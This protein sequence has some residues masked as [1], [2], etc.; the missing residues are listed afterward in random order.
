ME[1]ASWEVYW[2]QLKLWAHTYTAQATSLHQGS[3]YHK[4]LRV[5]FFHWVPQGGG[6][7]I[8]NQTIFNSETDGDFVCWKTIMLLTEPK[9][10]TT[11]C[12]Y[13]ACLTGITVQ[14]KR[15]MEFF[16]ISYFDGIIMTVAHMSAVCVACA[17]AAFLECVYKTGT[18]QANFLALLDNQLGLNQEGYGPNLCVLT[19]LAVLNSLRA[20]F[21]SLEQS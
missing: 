18:C 6:R 20:I 7:E 5:F 21:F 1:A 17:C 15:C 16:N 3:T 4:R 13:L 8:L 14:G 11:A 9:Q 12:V 19:K 2:N 10:Q